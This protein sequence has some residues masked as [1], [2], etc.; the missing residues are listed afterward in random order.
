MKPDEKDM[1]GYRPLSADL[2]HPPLD[3]L[4]GRIRVIADDPEK[5]SGRAEKGDDAT[6]VTSQVIEEIG[7][8]REDVLLTSPYFVPGKAAFAKLEQARSRGVSMTL[9]TNTMA[10]NDEPFVS[11]AYEKYRPTLLAMGVQIYEVSPAILIKDMNFSE[12]LGSSVGRLHAKILVLDRQTTLVGSMNFDLR[13]SRENTEL[14]LLVDSPQLAADVAELV[15][16]LRTVGTYRMRLS[17]QGNAVQ[18]VDD[19]PGGEEVFDSEPEISW[20][21]RLQVWLLS[22]FVSEGLL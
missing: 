5:V 6:T 7:K 15:G 8:A 14:G 12:P 11:A 16:A 22:P 4:R 21:T 18:W 10:S 3:M 9:V 20:S 17:P 13:S 1:L 19:Q 2:R